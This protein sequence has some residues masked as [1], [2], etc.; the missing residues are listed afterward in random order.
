V[1]ETLAV[2]NK[3]YADGA[4]LDATRLEGRFHAG[5]AW[6]F[7]GVAIVGFAPRSFAIVT[8]TM[9]LPPLVVH[10]HAAVM[11]S[12][13]TL[14]ALQAT[15]SLTGRMDL[16]RRW[17]LASLVIAP[18]VL[19]M[20]IG[21]TVVRQNAAFGTPGGP[22]VNNI[23]FLQIRSIVLFPT[24]FIW[25]LST[26]HTDPQMHKRMML[27][28]T[29]MLLD[30]A[31]A[32][33]SWLPFNEFPKSYLAVHLYLLLLLVPPIVYDFMRTRRIHRAWLWGLALTLPWVVAT[34]L[35]WDTPWWRDFG[36]KL[37]GAG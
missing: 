6:L 5:M 21:V 4:R 32:R 29:L 7:V 27:L 18:L 26:R 10:L 3:P 9:P 22:I 13:V 15:T 36:P 30:A 28:A 35:I 14:L 31:I 24:F 12:W 2:G 8:G 17:G 23:L 19:A 16:H 20:L 25:A 34:E 33:M 1:N 11:A 37:V